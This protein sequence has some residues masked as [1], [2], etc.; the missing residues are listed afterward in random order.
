MVIMVGGWNKKVITIK[1]QAKRNTKRKVFLFFIFKMEFCDF[2]YKNVMEFCDFISLI[3]MEFC[4]SLDLEVM[5]WN[6]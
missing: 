1:L 6:Y 5:K 2:I 4:D 3:C